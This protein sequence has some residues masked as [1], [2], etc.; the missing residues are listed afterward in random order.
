MPFEDPLLEGSSSRDR[1]REQDIQRTPAYV[2]Q[3]TGIEE[4]I[5]HANLLFPGVFHRERF[6][7]RSQYSR[8][9]NNDDHEH[10]SF[11]LLVVFRLIGR[12]AWEDG[13]RELLDVAK[14]AYGKESEIPTLATVMAT[15]LLSW[16]LSKSR[17]QNRFAKDLL[18]NAQAWL[19]SY[20]E[21]DLLKSVSHDKIRQLLDTVSDLVRKR[22]AG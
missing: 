4:G 13:L 15:I 7:Q 16:W 9:V 18:A 3:D 11:M 19:G 20:D 6:E 12:G 2:L 1:R 14:E 22:I 21:R 10:F 5:R 17:A 8:D